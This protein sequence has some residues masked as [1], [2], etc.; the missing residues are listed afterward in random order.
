MR[1]SLTSGTAPIPI[2]TA[3]A[4]SCR[5]LLVTT[6]VTRPPVPSNRS[7][8]SSPKVSIP[9]SAMRFSK[10]R[11]ACS[12]KW[13][14]RGT[15][16]SITSEHELPSSVREAATSHG[17]VGAPN[18]HHLLA[19]GVGA[20]RVGVAERPQVVDPLELGAGD[21]HAADTGAGGDERLLEAHL[22]AVGQLDAAL[23][24]IERFDRDA[25]QRLDL[26]LVVPVRGPEQGVLAR[27]VALEVALR[28]RRAV[29]RQVGLAPDQED[30][31]VG[32]GLAQPAGAVAGG[33]TASDE[34]I[35]NV[36]ISHDQPDGLAPLGANWGVICASRPGSRISST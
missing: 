31:P 21:R 12:P 16:S 34:R 25:S 18:H 35:A 2:T 10:K 3:S 23:G 29:V 32:A 9:C 20:D 13:R 17:D 33:E 15:D 28:A 36:P 24:Q 5:P 1:A 7:S 4:S 14:L 27:L 8:S 6:R 22:L 19:G 11:P 30:R 26:L